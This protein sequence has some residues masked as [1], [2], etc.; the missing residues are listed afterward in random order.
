LDSASLNYPGTDTLVLAIWL[1]EICVKNYTVRAGIMGQ[2][3]TLTLVCGAMGFLSVLLQRRDWLILIWTSFSSFIVGT[4]FF[5]TL[6]FI[7]KTSN[8]GF[9]ILRVIWD[10]IVFGRIDGGFFTYYIL[11]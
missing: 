5:S 9:Q 11:Q 4:Y 6:L 2:I 3:S 1:A 8:F 7:Q 10:N